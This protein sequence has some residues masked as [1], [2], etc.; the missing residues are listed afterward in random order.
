[1]GEFTAESRQR[2]LGG[3]DIG[4]IMGINPW[5]TAKELYK[6]KTTKYPTDINDNESMEWGRIHEFNV[7]DYY[8]R[9]HRSDYAMA[10][11]G[12]LK[13]PDY[14]YL[15]GHPDFVITDS[16]NS[17]YVEIL[18]V[19]TAGERMIDDWDEKPPEYYRIQ[20]L[21]YCLLYYKNYNKLPLA[22]VVVLI[23]GNKFRRYTIDVTK[24]ELEDIEKLAVDFWTKNIMPRV[25]PGDSLDC[26]DLDF[27]HHDKTNLNSIEVGRDT[28]DNI[29]EMEKL[30][31]AIAELEVKKE[32]LKCTIKE[33]MLDNKYA[34]YK[35]DKL[36]SNISIVK[37]NVKWKSVASH[38]EK[39]IGFNEI[40][41]KNSNCKAFKT[42]T[43]NY[44][45]AKYVK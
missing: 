33:V 29:L 27:I 11:G 13:H 8:M 17:D 31:V 26:S 41:A 39:E 10:S 24:K 7:A 2:Y 43:P 20:L 45:A 15:I 22:T 25:M 1:M 3:T 44:K 9:K 34:I 37:N 28:V 36:V 40:V 18:E 42:F 23:G 16:N 6:S 21:F 38:Y 19:K 35:G 12:D 32:E 30:T 4:A 14:H 5:C